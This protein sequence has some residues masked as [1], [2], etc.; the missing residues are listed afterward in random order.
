MGLDSCCRYILVHRD[1]D[2]NHVDLDVR[3]Y[4]V[5]RTRPMEEALQDYRLLHGDDHQISNQTVQA[6]QNEEHQYQQRIVD[7]FCDCEVLP[8]Y[9]EIYPRW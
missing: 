6:H 8:S 7:C 1:L 3:N 4:R 2:V 5:E 9:C